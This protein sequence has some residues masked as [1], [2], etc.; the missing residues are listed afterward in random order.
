MATIVKPNNWDKGDPIVASEHNANFDTIY[1]DYNGNIKNENVAADAAIA[2]S[3]LDLSDISGVSKEITEPSHGFVAAD[4]I[5]YDGANYVKAQADSAANAEAIGIVRTVTDA[6]TFTV[7]VGGF[8]TGLSGLVAG[9]VYFLSAATAGLLTSTEPTVLNGVSKPMLIA[10]STTEGW[11]LQMRGKAITGASPLPG[12]TVQV[13]NLTDGAVNSDTGG[14]VSYDDNPFLITE[15]AEYMTLAITPTKITN[16]LKIDVVW[17]GSNTNDIQC[18]AGLFN[19]DADAT[20]AIAVC[21]FVQP[22]GVNV[23]TNVSFTYFMTA[24]SVSSTTFRVRVGDVA[25]ATVI[26]M[27]GITGDARRFAGACASSITI[28]EIEV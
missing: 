21:G 11:V 2:S 8:I 6:N 12:Q 19:T 18:A 7:Q 15:G 9:D 4:V 26:T 27:N 16:K 24:P 14:A 13:V 17:V 28:T 10:T 20:D 25:G 22:P 3:K 1:N 23:Q 5:Y